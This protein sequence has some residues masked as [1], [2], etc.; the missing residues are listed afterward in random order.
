[1]DFLKGIAGKLVAGLV[2]LVVVI[3]AISWFQMDSSTRQELLSAA[4]RIFA[5][6][7]IVI[8]LPWATFFLT[9]AVARLESNAAGAALVGLYTLVEFL[10]LL[11]LFDWSIGG[12]LAWTFVIVGLLTA[13]L[14]NLL[15]CDWLAEK[16]A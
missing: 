16:L 8:V 12:A 11:W 14:Y 13:A 1:M 9:T 4:G 10:L 7:G 6:I 5:W 15:V 3:A 2:G